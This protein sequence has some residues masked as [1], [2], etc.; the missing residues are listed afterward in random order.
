MALNKIEIALLEFPAVI[1]PGEIRLTDLN[2]KL[3]CM[4]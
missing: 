4:V 3:D 2:D 1:S